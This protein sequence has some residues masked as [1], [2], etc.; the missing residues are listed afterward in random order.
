MSS[1][2][3]SC[4][5]LID[6]DEL[7]SPRHLGLVD[8]SMMIGAIVSHRRHV[9]GSHCCIDASCGGTMKSHPRAHQQEDS[10]TGAQLKA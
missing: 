7:H 2:M 10:E 9:G 8:V 1:R 6:V 4:Q 3:P 5:V